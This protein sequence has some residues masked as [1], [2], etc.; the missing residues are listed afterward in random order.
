M[1]DKSKIFLADARHA[2]EAIC[3]LLEPACDRIE[4][5][6]S[7][8]RM[9]AIVG[10][11]EIVCVPKLN[12]DG[13]QSLSMVDVLVE[14]LIPA[15]PGTLAFEG[16][17]DSGLRWNS[18][19]PANGSR[20]KRLIWIGQDGPLEKMKVDLFCVLPPAS[21]GALM[22]IR[23]GPAEFG[24]CLVTK[25][26][27]GGALPDRFTQRDGALWER[28]ITI[29]RDEWLKFDT[30]EEKDYF[31]ALGVP[32]WPPEDRTTERLKQHL[33]GASPAERG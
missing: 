20:Y 26:S 28:I 29:G 4:I 30:P 11:V 6:G 5:A 17:V 32:Y 8:R 23:T 16:H 14:Q 2:A 19:A 3:R 27:Q 31:A 10:D 25:R 15:G 24:R 18:K 33:A 1:S 21:W 7:I 12:I 22:A 13:E 9:S